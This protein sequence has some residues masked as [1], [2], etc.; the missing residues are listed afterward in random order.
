[1]MNSDIRKILEDVKDGSV[2]VDD[3][4]LA[5]KKQPFE[6][7]GFAKVDLHRSIRQGAPEVVYGAGKTSSQIEGIIK[8]M[9]DNDVKTILVTRLDKEKYKDISTNIDVKY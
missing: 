7:I 9:M 3:A 8:T 4:L 2:S 5:I 6:D 1:M